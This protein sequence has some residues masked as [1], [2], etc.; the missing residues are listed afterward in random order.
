MPCKETYMFRREVHIETYK[1][2]PQICVDERA[3]AQDIF[4]ATE[5]YAQT[6]ETVEILKR[7]EEYTYVSSA[8]RNPGVAKK[9]MRGEVRRACRNLQHERQRN[10]GMKHQEQYREKR[11]RGEQRA[12]RER[13]REKECSSARRDASSSANVRAI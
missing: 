10:K 9:K 5:I 1:E 13:Y 7:R 6:L 4:Y 8:A 3:K 2:N 11:E 12:C